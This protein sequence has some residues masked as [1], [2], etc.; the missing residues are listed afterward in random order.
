MQI[1]MIGNQTGS[2]ATWGWEEGEWKQK[3]EA[4]ATLSIWLILYNICN[5]CTWAGNISGACNLGEY[6]TIWD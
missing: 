5:T 4:L 6:A 2:G 3:L 1:E